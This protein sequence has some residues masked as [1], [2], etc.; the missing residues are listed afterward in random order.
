[1]KYAP[2]KLLLF[3]MLYVKAPVTDTLEEMH[4]NLI[5]LEETMFRFELNNLIA[6]AQ[7]RVRQASASSSYENDFLQSTQPSTVLVEAAREL[8]HMTEFEPVIELPLV[9][10]QRP[11]A[12][13]TMRFRGQ[14]NVMEPQAM[15]SPTE[16]NNSTMSMGRSLP[17]LR[18]EG[19]SR[20]LQV[21]SN[22]RT[23]R[24]RLSNNQEF[25]ELFTHCNFQRHHFALLRNCNDRVE[26]IIVGQRRL[27][28]YLR[29]AQDSIEVNANHFQ[30][31]VDNFE[32]AINKRITEI[33]NH[34]FLFQNMMLAQVTANQMIE[35]R[36]TKLEAVVARLEAVV[37][38]LNHKK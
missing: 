18:C 14:I 19:V 10:V 28:F 21:Q 24:L 20:S 6:T 33:N 30:R 13:R 3:F 32:A 16:F 26:E 31:S 9:E 5:E 7:V 2:T 17:S 1:M 29:N 8:E 4:R 22:E 25:D 34:Q 37:Q 38:S 15:E 35:E 12:R 11:L 27:S 36:M 23:R